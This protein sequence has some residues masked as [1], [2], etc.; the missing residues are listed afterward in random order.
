MSK[1]LKI[2]LIFSTTLICLLA[3]FSFLYLWLIPNIVSNPNFL[4][5]VQNSVK[6]ICGAEL[7]VENP[8][9]K[10][11]ISPNITFK[12][13]KISLIKN[14]ETLLDIK[15]FDCDFSLS[16]IFQKKIVLK[17]LGSDEIC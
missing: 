11:R 17:K 2:T 16:K 4:N 14:G 8:Y 7:I 1:N 10:T 12:T 13:N 3:F 15:N 5:F 6:E 9:L